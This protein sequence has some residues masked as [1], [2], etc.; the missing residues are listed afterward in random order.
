MSAVEPLTAPEA[1][2]PGTGL[3]PAGDHG[4]C[5]EPPVLTSATIRLWKAF[6]PLALERRRWALTVGVVEKSRAGQTYSLSDEAAVVVS[7]CVA[8]DA[9]GSGVAADILGPGDV[10]AT[11]SRRATSG[12]WIT[13]GELYR[14]RLGDWLEKAG[15]DGV[16]HL[17]CAADERRTI[18]EQRIFCAITHRATARVA[19]L[20]LAIHEAAPQPD[21]QL[22][23][24]RLGLMLGLRR[25]TVNGSCR[26]LEAAG[27]SR[28]KRG[29]I[30]ILD[31]AILSGLACGC[32]RTAGVRN[33]VDR[34]TGTG[35]REMTAPVALND[36][37][38]RRPL[39]IGHG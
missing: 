29:N 38:S 1:D 16:L 28:T 12:Q 2:T 11:G 23:Q 15:T 4:S 27:A 39:G 33:G 5:A 7:G 9:M 32:R 18:L 34:Q 20:F 25:T 22:S 21:I 19:D 14:V 8:T 24:E 10:L 26:S 37:A 31:P 36:D 6:S 30:R 3:A 13:D 35:R 17:M